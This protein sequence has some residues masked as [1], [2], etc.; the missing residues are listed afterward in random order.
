MSLA[1]PSLF[2]PIQLR[3]QSIRNRIAISPMCMYS[4]VDGVPND[5]HTAHLGSR[6]IGGAG[7]VIAE[8]TGVEPEGRITPGCT[9]LWNEEQADAF[10]RIVDLGHRHGASMGIQLG[11]AGRKGSTQRPWDGG[12]P[13]GPEEAWETVAPSALPHRP[14]WHVPHA[15]TAEEIRGRIAAFVHSAGLAARA[16]FDVIELHGAHGYLLHQFL[17]PIS[18]R[19]TDAY[20]GSLMNRARFLFE[21]VEAVRPVWGD[22]RPLFVRLSVS[23]HVP[24][25]LSEDDGVAVSRELARLG[26]DLIDV[27][28]GGVATVWPEE[29]PGFRAPMSE[30]IRREAAIS[31]APVGRIE[32]PGQAEALVREGRADMVIVGR[33]S[34]RDP[35]LGL[36]WAEALG[37]EMPWPTPYGAVQPVIAPAADA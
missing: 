27:T 13:L 26:V 9:G 14:N 34:L 2:S 16:G 36:H 19:R 3:G 5:W 21:V 29:S 33:A 20:G 22:D 25:G 18:N 35:Y 1:E 4:A 10:G 6:A 17:S 30:R 7:L 12:G 15:L 24:E 11:H 23:D 28:S 31:A 37:V 32:E 8:A